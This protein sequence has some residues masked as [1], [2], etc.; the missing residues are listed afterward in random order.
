MFTGAVEVA[1][2]RLLVSAP[3]KA[4]GLQNFAGVLARFAGKMDA[5]ANLKRILFDCDAIRYQV[6]S[7]LGRGQ[8]LEL[9]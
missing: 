4:I 5:N 9:V 8:L 7:R 3:L 2:P 1:L 6:L